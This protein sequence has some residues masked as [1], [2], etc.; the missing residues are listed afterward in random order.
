[1]SN[2]KRVKKTI[3][4]TH[5]YGEGADKMLGMLKE[6]AQRWEGVQKELVEKHNSMAA[7]LAAQEAM[8]KQLSQFSAMEFGKMQAKLN[9]WFESVDCALHHHDVTYIACAE[10]LKEVFGQLTQVDLYFR[11]ISGLD[12]SFSD[13]E[14]ETVKKDA[15]EWF[16]SVMVSAFKTANET[17]EMQ[18]Q[19]AEEARQQ[20]KEKLAAEK[21][22]AA[23]DRAE[24]ERM[25]SELQNAEKQ[26]RGVAPASGHAEAES[27][28]L[29]PDVRVFGMT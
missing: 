4:H 14:I 17:V 6:F 13:R 5:S 2:K 7:Q 26:D 28:G 10:I 1:M 19:A 25:E 9:L 27:L 24:A 11:R 23:A 20:E 22:Q 15:T 8:F 18:R 29:P 12:I 21:E 3:K 16:N